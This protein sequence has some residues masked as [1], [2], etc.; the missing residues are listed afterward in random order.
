VT[1]V[2]QIIDGYV[3]LNGNRVIGYKAAGIVVKVQAV[4]PMPVDVTVAV[5]ADVIL[6]WASVQAGVSTAIANYLYGLGIGND[7]IWTELTA[8]IA[9]APGVLDH[10][11]AT[12]TGNVSAAIGGRVIPGVVTITQA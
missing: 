1:N 3:D 5:N 7:L 10:H 4:A 8:A 9:T 2:Q 11:L 6:P 12:P